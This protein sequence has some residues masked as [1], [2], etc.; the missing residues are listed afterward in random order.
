MEWLNISLEIAQRTGAEITEEAIE[1]MVRSAICWPRLPEAARRRVWRNRGS[2]I[3]S[4]LNESEKRWLRPLGPMS[5]ALSLV[6]YWINYALMRTLFRLR[7]S[8]LENLPARGPFIIAPNHTSFLDPVALAAGS[9]PRL[10]RCTYWAGWT[11]VVFKGPICRALARLAQAV[12][13][14]PRGAPPPVLLWVRRC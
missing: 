14:D 8:G 13:I 2:R 5:K 7:Y 3:R 6:L 12:P 4:A 1:R 10:L 11:G 9:S